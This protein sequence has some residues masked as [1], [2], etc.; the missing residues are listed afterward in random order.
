MSRMRPNGGKSARF[1]TF[2]MALAFAFAALFGTSR[3]TPNPV[4]RLASFVLA[5]AADAGRTEWRSPVPASVTDPRDLV[6]ELEEEDVDLEFASARNVGFLPVV[7]PREVRAAVTIRSSRDTSRTL[8]R[9]GL[10]R[11]PPSSG[12]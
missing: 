8:R 11:G 9:T 10:P 1:A 3:S 7:V 5:A 6:S 12:V 2:A 4:P